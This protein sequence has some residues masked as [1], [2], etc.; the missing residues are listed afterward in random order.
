MVEAVVDI[1]WQAV[2]LLLGVVGMSLG[3]VCFSIWILRKPNVNQA[4]RTIPYTSGQS[5]EQPTETWPMRG[6]A[7]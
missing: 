6:Q 1:N 4:G 3:T 7:E 5:E 2:V